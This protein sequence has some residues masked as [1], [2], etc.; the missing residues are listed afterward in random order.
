MGDDQH[1]PLDLTVLVPTPLPLWGPAHLAEVVKDLKDGEQAGP[2]EQS[3][4]APNV[5][6]RDMKPVSSQSP[7]TPCPAH[8]SAPGRSVH[9]EQLGHFVGLLLLHHLVVECLKEDIQN[10]HVL[11][12]GKDGPGCRLD[13]FPCP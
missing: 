2:N 10:Q 7:G 3:H 12:G 9:T 8:T 5:A 11:P 6:C 4:L 1:L 13:T